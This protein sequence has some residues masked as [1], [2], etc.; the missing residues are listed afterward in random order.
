MKSSPPRSRKRFTVAINTVNLIPV[1]QSGYRAGR[2][3]HALKPR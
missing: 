2:N 1:Y 3:I